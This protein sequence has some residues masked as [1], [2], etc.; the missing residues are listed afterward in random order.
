MSSDHALIRCAIPT[1]V[2]RPAEAG[3]NMPLLI[4]AETRDG[5]RKNYRVKVSNAEI[6][7][8]R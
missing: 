4:A 1:R 3:R 8:A 5:V 7:L 2:D 6:A